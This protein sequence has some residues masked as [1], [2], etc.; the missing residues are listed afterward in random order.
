M[1]TA[2]DPQAAL[3]IVML[4][5][6]HALLHTPTTGALDV[7]WACGILGPYGPRNRPNARRASMSVEVF[8]SRNWWKTVLN[9]SSL[10]F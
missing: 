3:V 5:D 4:K 6:W 8:D 1:P 9:G 10:L 2:R 7:P